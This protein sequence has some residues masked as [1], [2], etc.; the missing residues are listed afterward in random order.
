MGSNAEHWMGTAHGEERGAA[1]WGLGSSSCWAASFPT[2][3][4]QSRMSSS[5]CVFKGLVVLSLES[6]EPFKSQKPE[7]F[8]RDTYKREYGAPTLFSTSSQLPRVH[9]VSSATHS[10]C[11]ILSYHKPEATGTE[12]SAEMAK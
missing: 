2:T 7:G 3:T 10:H 8:M 11:D 5:A 9:R 12:T 6:V 1:F 4:A